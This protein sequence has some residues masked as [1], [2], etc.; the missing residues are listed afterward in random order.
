MIGD[1]S[2]TNIGIAA[3]DV[4]NNK[5]RLCRQNADSKRSQ[6]VQA[7]RRLGKH[8]QGMQRRKSRF[9]KVKTIIVRGG[10]IS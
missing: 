2:K 6:A 4:G 3:G 7:G 10:E 9:S 5:G 1:A 8:W